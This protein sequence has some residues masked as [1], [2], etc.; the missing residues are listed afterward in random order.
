MLDIELELH[1]E[2]S[3]I[4]VQLILLYL[5]RRNFHVRLDIHHD[6]NVFCS[7]ASDIGSTEHVDPEEGSTT[8]AIV[9]Q[10]LLPQKH[11]LPRRLAPPGAANIFHPQQINTASRNDAMLIFSIPPQGCAAG[12]HRAIIDAP[13]LMAQ[14][15]I[16]NRDNIA[17]LRQVELKSGCRSIRRKW[18]GIKQGQRKGLRH[19]QGRGVF[20]DR[21][22]FIIIIF[23]ILSFHKN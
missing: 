9:M 11:L 12:R 18:V 8:K 7:S 2:I 20:M 6:E 17:A 16:N 14:E 15:I 4:T 19:A 1:S 3:D 23:I 5:I 22:N 10:S 13:N 21:G